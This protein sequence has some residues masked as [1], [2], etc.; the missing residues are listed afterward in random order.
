MC[1]FCHIPH[2]QACSESLSNR[3][4]RVFI[5]K[6]NAAASG[7]TNC[8][9]GANM[10]VEST[11]DNPELF[12][13]LVAPI[14]VDLDIIQ[15][16]L[17]D[18]LKSIG[19]DVELIRVTDLMRS[20]HSD[21]KIKT[22]NYFNQ[23]KSLID[24]ADDIRKKAKRNDALALLAIQR[25]RQFRKNSSKNNHIDAEKR[26]DAPIL[27]TAY[28]LR[29][30]KR[31]EEVKLL[32]SIYG[33]KFI[34]IS[35][36][37]DKETRKKNLI[38]KIKDFE[39]KTISEASAEKQAIDLIDIDYH[40]ISHDHGQRISDVFHLG[41]VFVSG[42]DKSIA[43]RTIERFIY[44]LFG[45]NQISPT[46]MEYG[47]Y[48]AAGAALRS[49]DLSRQVG[50]AVFSAE[51][52]VIT[53]GCN[54][55]PKA[56][57][58]T[59]WCDDATPYRDFEAGK[60]AN[61][62]RK[63]EI[64]HDFIERLGKQK[65]LSRNFTNGRDINS[66]VKDLIHDPLIKESQMMDIIEFGR[67]IHA[68]MLAIT[69]AARLG[70]PLK[71][72]ILYCTTFPCHMCAKH[73]V[74]SGVRRVVFLEPYPKSYAEHLHADSIS[75]ND[76]EKETHVVFEPFIGISP[77]RYRDIF[78]KKKRKSA[79][80]KPQRW[81]YGKQVPQ[82]EDRSAAYIEY[83]ASSPEMLRHLKPNSQ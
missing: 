58:G 15:Q 6:P 61:Q 79:D 13:G 34:Q 16:S 71:N 74:S 18:T 30:F 65:I 48:A 56:F 83:E 7:I 81:Y 26:A 78:E 21:I 2:P 31:E 20:F 50:A 45:D 52:E 38:T 69:D 39:T 42:K 72:S 70:K 3:I 76:N 64:L 63:T 5:R 35:V 68:E 44:A 57:G 23:Y 62:Q 47:M 17:A 55:V 41:D 25:I 40:E 43:D 22:D 14:G 10:S 4:T 32:R 59:Y 33:R 36:Y 11:I 28:I 12:F 1:Y 29:Q 80:G 73:I 60:D 27:G 82:I 8:F 66:Q 54:E 46:R 19:Y 67:M 53:L 9:A 51:G 24:Y 49:I 37:T 77:R 75:F